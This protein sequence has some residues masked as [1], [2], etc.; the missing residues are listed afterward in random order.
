MSLWK[1]VELA[2]PVLAMGTV[3]RSIL[4][5]VVQEERSQLQRIQML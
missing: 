1:G 3:W 5:K 2:D 4:R